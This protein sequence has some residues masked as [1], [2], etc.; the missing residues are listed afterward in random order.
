MPGPPSPAR[1]RRR[2]PR[3]VGGAHGRG[4]TSRPRAAWSG[5]TAGTSVEDFAAIVGRRPAVAMAWIQFNGIYDRAI[6]NS[7]ARTRG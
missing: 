1:A 7:A 6:E 4:P 5:V 3:R 2:A